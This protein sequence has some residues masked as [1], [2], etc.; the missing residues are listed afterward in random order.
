MPAWKGAEGGAVRPR[1]LPQSP[2]Q[3]AG[4]A[5]RAG[6]QEC[7]VPWGPAGAWSL[8]PA[9]RGVCDQ[10]RGCTHAHTHT[11]VP[12]HTH[13]RPR[14]GQFHVSQHRSPWAGPAEAAGRQGAPRRVAWTCVVGGCPLGEGLT[15]DPALKEGPPL[16]PLPPP[17]PPQR[18]P[19]LPKGR[20]GRERQVGWP[21][22][23]VLRGEGYPPRGAS[24]APPS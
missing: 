14:A 1:A 17:P 7:G 8:V 9:C 3:T 4:P 22:A 19:P 24:V 15:R 16:L 23:G 18:S 20:A 12:V 5:A 6:G 10:G 11:S 21:G 13:A 2:P